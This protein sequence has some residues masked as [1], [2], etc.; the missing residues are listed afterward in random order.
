MA[1]RRNEEETE[2][3]GPNLLQIAAAAGVG[4]VAYRNRNEI[5]SSVKKLTANTNVTL[6]RTTNN[7]Q[8]KG[9]IGE[10]K[11]LSKAF[12][13]V[14]DLSPKGIARTMRVGG[15]TEQLNRQL[16][17]YN[18]GMLARLDRQ[19]LSDVGKSTQALRGSYRRQATRAAN[20]KNLDDVLFN[21]SSKISKRLD[22]KQKEDIYHLVRNNAD[23]IFDGKRRRGYSKSG[24]GNLDS[25]LYSL[26]QK[27][28]GQGGKTLDLGLDTS[29]KQKGFME[30]LL[31]VVEETQ[32]RTIEQRNAMRSVKGK[33]FKPQ[34]GNH[35]AQ[36]LDLYEIAAFDSV[37]NT[38]QAKPDR[39][40]KMMQESG[41][42]QVTMGQARKGM[43][44]GKEGRFF[45]DSSGKTPF[46]DIYA[47]QNDADITL[48]GGAGKKKTNFA[49]EY[50]KRGRKYGIPENEL[51]NDIFSSKLFMNNKTGEII[52]TETAGVLKEEAL[53]AMTSSYQ[54]PFMQFNPL[55]FRPGMKTKGLGEQSFA[56]LEG[57]VDI[58]PLIKKFG[59]EELSPDDIRNKNAS[60]WKLKDSQLFVSDKIIGSDIAESLTG[61]SYAARYQQFKENADKYSLDGT[62]TLA[63][64]R[65]GL[66]KQYGEAMANL[67]SRDDLD[68]RNT[69]QKFLELGG[70]ERDSLLTKTK[71]RFTKFKDPLYGEN[72]LSTID[73]IGEFN[74]ENPIGAYQ[75]AI[76]SLQ[77]NLLGATRNLDPNAREALYPV[78]SESLKFSLPDAKEV[79]LFKMADDDYVI[80]IAGRIAKNSKSGRKP[81]RTANPESIAHGLEDRIFSIYNNYLEDPNAFNTGARYLRQTEGLLNGNKTYMLDENLEKVSKVDDLRLFIEQYAI[82]QADAKGMGLFSAI[83]NTPGVDAESANEQLSALRALSEVNFFK[84]QSETSDTKEILESLQNFRGHFKEGSFERTNLS[85]ALMETDGVV[86]LGANQTKRENLLGRTRYL[87]VEKN[88]SILESFNAN[89]VD[90]GDGPAANVQ[91]AVQSVAD[92][93]SPFFAGRGGNITT[94]SI[95]PWFMANRLDTTLESYGLGLPQSSKGS[96]TSIVTRQFATRILAPYMA[97]QYAMYADGLTGDKVSDTAADTYV[98]MHTD[99]N[100]VKEAIGINAVGRDVRRIAPWLEQ[101]DEVPIFKLGNFATLGA[102]SDFR[103]AEEVEEYY[104]SGEDP[105]RKG[106]YWDIGSN[107]PWM[108]DRIERYEPNWYRKMKSDYQFTDTMYG[109]EKE[110]WQNHW[111]PTPTNPFAPVRHFLADPYHY[112]KKHAESRPYV[113]TGGFGELDQIPLVGPAA[114]RVVSSVLKPEKLNPKFKTAHQELLARENEKLV[115]SYINMNAGGTVEIKGGSISLSSD[116]YNAN[117]VDDE[118]ELSEEE[119]AIDAERFINGRHRYAAT[120]SGTIGDGKSGGISGGN[121][122]GRV[123]TGNT[124]NLVASSGDGENLIN[125]TSYQQST[126]EMV[127]QN[128]VDGRTVN[129][130]DQVSR[131]GTLVNPNLVRDTNQV[132]NPNALLSTSGSL[133]DIYY[134]MGEMGGMYGFLGNRFTG[135]EQSGRG[136]TL[137]TSDRFGSLNDQFWDAGLGG[138]GGDVSEIFRRYLPRDPNRDYYNPIRNQ[139]PAWLPSDNYFVDF[140]RGDP[141]NKVAKGEM[142]LPGDS[143]ETLYNVQ[144]DAYGNYSAMDRYR[145]LADVAPYSDEYRAAKKEMALL[146]Q[147]GMLSDRQQEEYRELR[148]QTSAKMKKKNFY[149]ERFQNAD[150][151]RRTITVDRVI[152]ANTFLSVEFPN[153]PI[154]LAGVTIKAD[155]EENKALVASMIKQGQT[156][157]VGLD[158][159]PLRRVRDDMMDTMRAVVYTPQSV[160]G[161]M[162]GLR[163]L[164]KNQNLNY[165]LSQQDEVSVRDDGSATSTAALF[166]DNQRAMGELSDRI[167]HDIMPTLPIMNII[168]DKFLRVQSPLEAYEKEVYSKSWRSWDNPITG[169]V[170]P[171]LE[172]AAG[173]NPGL[174]FLHGAGIGFLSAPRNRWK[175]AWIGGLTFGTLAGI[176][177]VND[178]IDDLTPFGDNSAWVPKRRQKERNIDEYFDRLTYVKYKGLY[179]KAV[180]DAAK[181]EGTDLNALF[182]SVDEDKKMGRGLKDYLNTQK[183]WL[184]IQK[185]VGVSNEEEYDLALADIRKQLKEGDE[186]REYAQVGPYTALALRYKDTYESTLYAAGV[187]DTYDYNKIYR[188]L[189]SKDKQ[190]FTEFQKASPR[191]RERILELVPENQRPI[192]QRFYGLKIDKPE[193][194]QRY[195]KDAVLPD[196]NWE[197][198]EPDVSLDH[199]KIKVMRD[200]GIELTEA[201]FWADDEAAADASGVESIPMTPNPFSAINQ[202]E[203]EK[204]LRGAGL[205]DV[206]IQMVSAPSEGYGVQTALNIQKDRRQ[207]VEAGLRKQLSF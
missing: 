195:F 125:S 70:Q 3:R 37:R 13:E 43:I 117:F 91:A 9:V 41:W 46:S 52:N 78:L 150:I 148:K 142:R 167:V 194:M 93:A 128:L 77:G 64:G 181:Y 133:R 53:D 155:D 85:S 158:R 56:I 197:G 130:D 69:I 188:A 126:L 4:Y 122:T 66:Y 60:S 12:D 28:N 135:F 159:D 187:G 151:E 178:T 102:F 95:G 168:T 22:S 185:K 89:L 120:I 136:P 207:E 65:T 160:E 145:I 87:A 74:V 196:E 57:G 96:A 179:N 75:E 163:G 86:G 21:E 144:K 59:L 45:L 182:A 175:G 72:I 200:E 124:A 97:F 92:W 71:K 201:N 25:G 84:K 115:S 140:L 108:G 112:E 129:R 190:Y 61:N 193:S 32:G 20:I 11:N 183:K 110:Y 123:G 118:G 27:Y 192:Y 81:G 2:K 73:E 98:N 131:A 149:N 68:S 38:H 203:L 111:M 121:I 51:E 173:K 34:P 103:S 15:R 6:A 206:R 63:N 157:E 202:G 105:I 5:F 176:R 152:D 141:Y 10:A 7:R 23:E 171:M 205:Q 127:N 39:F 137:E 67:T 109:S 24:D 186:N 161:S 180:E 55:Q 154:K 17:N 162:M 143:Y 76:S 153:N 31:A 33:Q 114:N 156:L 184:T 189:P 116:S 54:I 170:Q 134:N 50:L 164:G 138:L 1:R 174:S 107:S 16:K 198:W 79:D 132:V 99:V 90:A 49:D 42:N 94:S 18:A 29:E 48:G 36:A 119:L 58:Q 14:Y 35:Y 204:V 88:Q 26:M 104:R 30:N 82:A 165:Y 146:N 83:K 19:P 172:S 177:T 166:T 80:D 8:F 47:G 100:R 101:L 139:M 40:A 191:E 62:F 199:V 169:W 106:R 147:N 44:N 113:L